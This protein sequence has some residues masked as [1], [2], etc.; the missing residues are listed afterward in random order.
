MRTFVCEKAVPRF[1][2]HAYAGLESLDGV[3]HSSE[4]GM[5]PGGEQHV[6]I[7]PIILGNDR[8]RT[9]RHELGH[10][11]GMHHEQKRP[12]PETSSSL[13]TTLTSSRSV[14]MISKS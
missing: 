2:R 13:S 6:A 12:D 11:M 5:E 1:I 7:D 9:A 3:S 4:L 10:A 14:G 8:K